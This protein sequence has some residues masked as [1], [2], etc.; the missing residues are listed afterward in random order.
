MA[1]LLSRKLSAL[2]AAVT[3][4]EELEGHPIFEPFLREV[5]SQL[6]GHPPGGY[7]PYLPEGF[8]VDY[9]GNMIYEDLSTV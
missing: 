4:T 3:L 2:V 1:T 6:K 7:D 5:V 9:L 8:T